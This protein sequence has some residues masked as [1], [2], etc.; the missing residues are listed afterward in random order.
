MQPIIVFPRA[1][2]EALTLTA[3]WFQCRR[4]KRYFPGGRPLTH[5]LPSFLQRCSQERLGHWLLLCQQLQ[6]LRRAGGAGAAPQGW[7]GWGWAEP[8]QGS[9]AGTGSRAG[10]GVQDAFQSTLKQGSRARATSSTPRACPRAPGTPGTVW[11]GH[12][13]QPGPRDPAAVTGTA[14]DPKTKHPAHGSQGQPGTQK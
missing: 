12:R 3:G 13:A 2:E 7:R 14:R 11:G 10:A 1:A 4:Q 5:P 9:T 6:R 8:G